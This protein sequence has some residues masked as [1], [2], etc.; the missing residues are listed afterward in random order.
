MRCLTFVLALAL[1]AIPTMARAQ[2]GNDAKKGNRGDMR[3]SGPCWD[4]TNR[5][6]N[7]NNGTV[8]DTRSTPRGL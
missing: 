3:A 2:P 1:L 8:I 7:C 6:V 4:N 5:Y